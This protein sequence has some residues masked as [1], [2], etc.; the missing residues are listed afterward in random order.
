MVFD[1]FGALPV[2]LIHKHVMILILNVFFQDLSNYQ[3]DEMV[4]KSVGL[5]NKYYSAR[6]HLF[7]RAVHS[8][9]GLQSQ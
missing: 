8:Q 4:T 6:A 3:Y 9:V 1:L 2:V 5:M 7:R